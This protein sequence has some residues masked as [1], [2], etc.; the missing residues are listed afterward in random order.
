M[1]FPK[2]IS[3]EKNMENN[4][5]WNSGNPVSSQIKPTQLNRTRKKN[6]GV[7]SCDL[8]LISLQIFFGSFLVMVTSSFL[9]MCPLCAEINQS[10]K[11]FIDTWMQILV[12]LNTASRLWHSIN[13]AYITGDFSCPPIIWINHHLHLIISACTP[14]VARLKRERIYFEPLWKKAN[15]KT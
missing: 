7:C 1:F 14:I 4:S 12:I 15:F 13:K 8:W 2:I 5:I 10:L 3:N 11:Y 9:Q 6:E